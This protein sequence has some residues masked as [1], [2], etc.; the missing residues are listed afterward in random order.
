MAVS[1]KAVNNFIGGLRK[2]AD[3]VTADM[4]SGLL[5]E[6]KSLIPVLLPTVIGFMG[7]RK[8]WAFLKGQIKSA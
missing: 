7:F 5:S 3:I 6:I 8:G 2:M 1:R 4:F